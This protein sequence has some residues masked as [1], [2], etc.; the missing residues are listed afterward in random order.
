MAEI[1]LMED[2][3]SLRRI[4]TE[5]LRTVGHNVTALADGSDS[6]DSGFMERADLVITDLDMPNVDGRSVVENI[7]MSQPSLPVIVITG[8]GQEAALGVHCDET[9]LKPVRM[10]TLVAAVENCLKGIV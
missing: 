3:A 10:E 5:G 4:L 1:F 8:L 7:R 2:S 9:I 6:I